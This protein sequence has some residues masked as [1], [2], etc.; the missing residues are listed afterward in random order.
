M[1]TQCPNCSTAFRVLPAQLKARAGTVRC[2]QCNFIFNALETL[3]DD[4][5]IVPGETAAMP[6]PIEL[7]TTAESAHESTPQPAAEAISQAEDYLDNPLLLE[8][9]A[10]TRRW[11][12]ALGSIVALS[13]LLLQAAYYYR[14]ELAVLRP[15]LRP[16]LQ[17]ACQ[18]LHCDVPRPSNI[19]TL[20]IDTSDLRPDPQQPGHL[21]LTATLRSKAVYAQEWPAL[22]LTLTDVADHNVA[23]KHFAASD[24]L[25]K[26]KDS[27]SKQ[28]AAGFPA[29]G[30][31]AVVLPLDV[32]DLPAVG[33]R[34][35]IFYP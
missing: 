30:E 22:E 20:G 14:I 31:I 34:L 2:G 33:Y 35:Y 1:L 32:G 10:K 16:L 18:P 29:N 25:P 15:D 12:W 27:G 23:V 24:Y 11:P 8:P 9:T 13:G 7:S 28:I 3:A 21:T 17:T 5:I 4:P 6:T 26:D 19:D